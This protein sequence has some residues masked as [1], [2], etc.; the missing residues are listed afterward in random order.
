MNN[1]I[2]EK[3]KEINESLIEL[4]TFQEIQ[5]IN[6]FESPDWVWV[7][8]KKIKISIEELLKDLNNEPE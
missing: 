8:L 2:I 5:K 7:L 6:D 1:Y 3:L 4:K